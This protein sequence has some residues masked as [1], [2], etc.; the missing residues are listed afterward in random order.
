MTE[1]INLVKAWPVIIQGAL[2]S[3]LFWILLVVAQRAFN[4]TSEYFSKRS[5]EQSRLNKVQED[6]AKLQ[7]QLTWVIAIIDID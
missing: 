3:A 1:S 6:L 7:E 2:G 4:F 5:K